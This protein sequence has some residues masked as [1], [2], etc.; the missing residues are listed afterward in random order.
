[1]LNDAG[2]YI[3]ICCVLCNKPLKRHFIKATDHRQT[4]N[5]NHVAPEGHF[6]IISVDGVNVGALL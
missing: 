6:Y 4:S 3:P 2:S 5:H 1:M